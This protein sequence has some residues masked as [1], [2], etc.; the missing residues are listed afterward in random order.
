[1]N[2]TL[3]IH[4]PILWSDLSIYVEINIMYYNII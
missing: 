1:M 3:I 2:N 4:G